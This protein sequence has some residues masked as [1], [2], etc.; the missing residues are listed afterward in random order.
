MCPARRYGS[1]LTPRLAPASS[2]DLA[3][4]G[5]GAEKHPRNQHCKKQSTSRLRVKNPFSGPGF[6]IRPRLNSWL[7][8]RC[9]PFGAPGYCL[10]CCFCRTWSLS[11][12]CYS[13]GGQLGLVTEAMAV[14]PHAFARCPADP[15][16]GTSSARPHA[17]TPICCTSFRCRS[18]P[19]AKGVLW[20]GGG[21]DFG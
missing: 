8:T 13:R 2:Q 10:Q 19:P 14:S 20:Q 12:C 3:R 15:W 9:N 6:W 4:A 18:G 7:E 17:G 1:A 21:R 5:A 16:G 11:P